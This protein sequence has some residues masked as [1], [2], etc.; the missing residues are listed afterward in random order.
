MTRL[1]LLHYVLTAP[2]IRSLI[3][4]KELLV[5]EGDVEGVQEVLSVEPSLYANFNTFN[6]T[7]ND[8]TLRK[9]RLVCTLDPSS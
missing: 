4:I 1:Q 7:L 5:F 6:E 9:I 3:T 2:G 8:P